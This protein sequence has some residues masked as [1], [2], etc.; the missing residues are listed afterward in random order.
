[1]KIN[2]FKKRQATFKIGFILLSILFAPMFEIH[3]QSKSSSTSISISRSGTRNYTYNSNTSFGSFSIDYRGEIQLNDD[4][5]DIKSIS[6]GGYFKVSKTTFGTKRTVKIENKGDNQLIRTFYVGRSKEPYYPDGQKWLA[7][8]LPEIIRNTG[9]AAEQRVARFFKKSGT[10]G[11]LDEISAIHS[12]Y[13]KAK[14]FNALLELTGLPDKDIPLI[15]GKI[16]SYMDSSYEIGKLLGSH[17]RRFVQNEASAKAFFKAAGRISSDYEKSKLL[18]SVLDDR[19]LNDGAFGEALYAA[20]S[21]SSDY[22]VG[23]VLKRVLENEDLSSERL[24]QVMRI[25]DDVS[26]DYEKGK[27]LK[28]LM[29]RSTFDDNIFNAVLKSSHEISSDYEM[30]KVL[31]ELISHQDLDEKRLEDVLDVVDGISSD[32]EKK[33]MLIYLLDDNEFKG[34]NLNLLLEMVE[35]MS[36]SHEKGNM[37]KTILD[38]MDLTD[39]QMV[40]LLNAVDDISSDH[41]KASLLIKMANEAS[42]RGGKV[43][44]AYLSVAKSINSDHSYGQVMRAL[45]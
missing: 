40:T 36:S 26:S 10:S 15:I 2:R 23:K 25:V 34:S 45:E 29:T 13:V 44:A 35:D 38:D 33:K 19:R 14:Y 1:M 5:T 3:A 30:S 11:V 6:E 21:I 8:I 16:D 18:M 7:D 37:Y 41:E 39:D 12:D 27:I 28:S 24:T 17:S 32:Y 20:E 22:E 4:E 43:K 31:K 42:K 9:I